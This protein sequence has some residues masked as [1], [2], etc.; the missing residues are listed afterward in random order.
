MSKHAHSTASLRRASLHWAGISCGALAALLLGAG[1]AVAQDL[2]EDE[3]SE[4]GVDEIILAPDPLQRAQMSDAVVQSMQA[5]GA[6]LA[7]TLGQ[8]S[9]TAAGTAVIEQRGSSSNRA[10][11]EQ[12]RR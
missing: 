3:E 7:E 5:D 8:Q 4:L 6:R 11:I 10:Q 9:Q 12:F 2:A 1:A